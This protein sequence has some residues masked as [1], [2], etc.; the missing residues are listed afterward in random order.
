MVMKMTDKLKNCPFCGGEAYITNEDNY[1]YVDDEFLICCEKC[2]LQ[3]G[4]ANQYETAEEAIE[5]WNTRKPIDG[6]VEKL[7]E[8]MQRHI[9]EA[10]RQEEYGNYYNRDHER[11]AAG[12]YKYFIKQLKKGVQNE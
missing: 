6:I 8:M 10:K 1:G 3:F 9:A 5:A 4:F 2:G 11:Y 7:E 12:T